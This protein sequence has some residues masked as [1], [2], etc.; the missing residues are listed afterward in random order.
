MATRTKGGPAARFKQAK[1]SAYWRDEDARVVLDVWSASGQ[2]VAAFAH[3]HG[4]QRARLHRWKQR[5]MPD[6]AD[7]VGALFWPVKVATEPSR[8]PEVQTWRV[9]LAGGVSIEVPCAGG[10]ALLAETLAAIREGWTC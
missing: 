2:S 3:E 8:P 1:R 9:E 6:I 10:A 5:L 7:E 4:L